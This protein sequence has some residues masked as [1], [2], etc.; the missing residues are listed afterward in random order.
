MKHKCCL[1]LLIVVSLVLLCFA[2]AT[3]LSQ[4]RHDIIC[5]QSNIASGSIELPYGFRIILQQQGDESLQVWNPLDDTSTILDGTADVVFLMVTNDYHHLVMLHQVGE[6]YVWERRSLVSGERQLVPYDAGPPAQVTELK[7]GSIGIS[8]GLYKN[9]VVDF[10]AGTVTDYQT[11]TRLETFGMIASE[12]YLD[13][14]FTHAAY[15]RETWTT[16]FF[17]RDL[18]NQED[19]VIPTDVNLWRS[20]L[21][22]S[23][24]D[25]MAALPNFDRVVVI[26]L[27]NG[28][29]LHD[30]SE[31]V[32]LFE[33]VGDIAIAAGRLT[34]SPDS[35]L[36]AVDY[37]GI[38]W[39][40]EYKYNYFT[41]ENSPADWDDPSAIDDGW[42]YIYDLET[43][44][45]ERCFRRER[46]VARSAGL[47]HYPYWTPDGRYL[48]WL[49]EQPEFTRNRPTGLEG[50]R[51]DH[52]L[53]L[54]VADLETGAY[55]VVAK[56]VGWL[57]SLVMVDD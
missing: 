30:T 8:T 45:Q 29:I 25:Q 32:E 43:G 47:R 1:S 3:V 5:I 27:E 33:A 16:G 11:E 39:S 46:S 50:L 31:P 10:A 7:N 26:S 48:W 2:S 28:R 34:W 49:E 54:V 24:D 17:I 44:V 19:V 18:S 52:G 37:Q 38:G 20:P 22:W 36:L 6:N 40:W 13:H 42:V 53:D 56:D 23:P 9:L 55:G 14:S 15:W 41:P 51:P 12:F 57:S 35:N 21:E 4:S